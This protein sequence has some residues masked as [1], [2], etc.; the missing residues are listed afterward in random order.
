MNSMKADIIKR[1]QETQGLLQ[2]VTAEAARLHYQIV[3]AERQLAH[4]EEVK[5]ALQAQRELL[6]QLA[7]SAT[8]E[9]G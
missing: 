5:A 3:E 1:L 8:E 6:Q 2:Q 9:E 7:Q 4:A